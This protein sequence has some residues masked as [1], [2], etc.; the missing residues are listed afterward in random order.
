MDVAMT[1]DLGA[2]RADRR[3]TR[4]Q[5]ERVRVVVSG[6]ETG[7]RYA[8]VETVE[9]P[10]SER[11]LHLHTRE[12]ELVYVLQGRAAF[13]KGDEDLR[14]GPGDRVLLPRGCEHTFRVESDEARLLVL[15]TPAGLEGLYAELVKSIDPRRG[16]NPRSMTRDL[17]RLVTASAR[18]GVEITGPALGAE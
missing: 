5:S 16:E 15:L 11:P 4:E 7:G 18:Y 17:D 3:G 1:G 9:R 12:D 13:Y 6:E 14:C 2:I 8:V 10:G